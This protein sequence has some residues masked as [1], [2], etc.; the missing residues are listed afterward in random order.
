M[1]IYIYT[2]I[3]IYT[4]I[5]VYIYIYIYIYVHVYI[6]IFVYTYNVE[7]QQVMAECIALQGFVM[8]VR[9]ASVGKAAIVNPQGN[10]QGNIIAL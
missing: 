8:F 1:Y 3:C 2:Y 7:C 10:R 6:Y 9:D 5:H 4:D